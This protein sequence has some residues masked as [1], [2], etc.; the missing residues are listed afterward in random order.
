MIQ[1]GFGIVILNWDSSLGIGVD[2]FVNIVLFFICF[3]KV[4]DNVS[5]VMIGGMFIL[6]EILDENGIMVLFSGF[7]V[8]VICSFVFE[9]EFGQIDIVNLI[10]V[11]DFIGLV[12]I[13]NM[14]NGFD[15]Y[16]YQWLIVGEIGLSVSGLGMGDVLVIVMD[17]NIGMLVDII[18]IIIFL[19]VLMGLVVD[20]INIFC[21]GESIGFII[22]SVGGGVD[23]FMYNWSGIL[24][25]NVIIQNNLEEGFYNVMI[26]DVNNC[27]LVL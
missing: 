10:C 13:V 12:I 5:M 26:I 4:S 6:I 11:D 1:F 15:N 17:I 16:D 9:L 8:Q 24:M 20:I 2:L 21:V 19:L 3:D 25:D 22:I 27:M 23:L 18:V 14:I 7:I